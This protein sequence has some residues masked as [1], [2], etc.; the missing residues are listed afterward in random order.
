MS[1][2][3]IVRVGETP[4]QALTRCDGLIT[5]NKAA[6]NSSE[7]ECPVCGRI[8]KKRRYKK[9][10]GTPM[11]FCTAKGDDNCKDAY[12][13]LVTEVRLRGSKC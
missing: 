9:F 6:H 10:C 13:N 2:L 4:E 1:K 11:V 8:Y 7:L 12:W 5:F 3:S